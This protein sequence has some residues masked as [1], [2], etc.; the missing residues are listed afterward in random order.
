MQ[1][2]R[3]SPAVAPRVQILRCGR[4][5][6]LE[7]A[8]PAAR[9]G[10]RRLVDAPHRAIG[11]DDGVSREQRLVLADEGVE[12]A[13]A[14]LFLALEHELD[15]D[16]QT[17]RGREERLGH[18]DR[19]QHR[20]L[21]VGDAAGVEAAVAHRRR[22][23]RAVPFVERVGRLHVVVSVHQH[24]R[25]ARRA[26]PLAVDDRV[27]AGGKRA[28]R[29]RT[30]RRH[31]RRDPACRPIDVGCVRGIGADA[32]DRRELD[33]LIEDALVIRPQMRQHP[34]VGHHFPPSIDITWPVIQPA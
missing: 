21:V 34:R 11:R 5:R 7:P 1:R 29:E 28:H 23:R 31:S 17:T 10:E 24:R 3:H 6:D 12:V 20:P 13:A 2:V 27:A 14:D 15:V 16:G 9:H 25:L 4:E 33:E 32:R 26:Q 18:G 22:P 19:N 8:E 30:G